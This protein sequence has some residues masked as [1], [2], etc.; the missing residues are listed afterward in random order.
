MSMVKSLAGFHVLPNFA[1][2]ALL[3]SYKYR[4]KAAIPK[5]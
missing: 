1:L 2:E 4:N 5:N 3:P